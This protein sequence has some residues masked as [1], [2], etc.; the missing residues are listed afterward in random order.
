L[1]VAGVLSSGAESF[2]VFP[3]ACVEVPGWERRK[4]GWWVVLVSR[5]ERGGWC[6][7]SVGQSA[8]GCGLWEETGARETARARQGRSEQASGVPRR[9]G[10]SR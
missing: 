7:R 5:R 4:G 3:Q 1:A 6:W 2:Q 10:K 9:D 8:R